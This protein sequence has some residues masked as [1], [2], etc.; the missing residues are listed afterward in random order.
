MGKTKTGKNSPTECSLCRFISDPH[1]YMHW[2]FRDSPTCLI[3]VPNTD[4]HKIYCIFKNH[5]ERPGGHNINV[6]IEVMLR[7]KEP[8]EHLEY[9]DGEHFF[10][11]ID[12]RRRSK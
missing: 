10:I 5:K 11:V 2:I 4:I 12:T 9:H 8:G 3:G 7:L 6:M 1:R